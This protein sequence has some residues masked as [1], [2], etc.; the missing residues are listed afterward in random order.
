M[1]VT[2]RRRLGGAGEVVVDLAPLA[3]DAAAALLCERVPEL[4]PAVAQRVAAAVD[5]LPLALELVAARVAAVGPEGLLTTAEQLVQRG[6]E[7][8]IEAS[9]TAARPEERAGL[10]ALTAF[11]GPF[12]PDAGEAV[13]A[14]EGVLD[15]LIAQS[16]VSRQGARLA[17]LE[18]VR[19]YARTHGDPTPGLARHADWFATDVPVRIVEAEAVVARK[20]RLQRDH[21]ELLAVADRFPDDRGARAM[22]RVFPWAVHHLPADDLLARLKRVED[23]AADPVLAARLT[24]ERGAVVRSTGDS[25]GAQALFD[26]ATGRL[27]ALGAVHAAAMSCLL[28]AKC[29]SDA[30]DEDDATARLRRGIDLATRA[31]T[32]GLRAQAWT[33]LAR[34]E[35]RRADPRARDH[36]EL[37]LRLARDAGDLRTV[38]RALVERSR[39]HVN[40][41]NVAAAL[42]DVAQAVAICARYE[43]VE[44][45]ASALNYEAL[46]RIDAGQPERAADIARRSIRICRRIGN[47]HL[48]LYACSA[49]GFALVLADRAP[50]AATVLEEAQQRARKRGQQGLTATLRGDLGLALADLGRPAAIDHLTRASE[51]FAAIGNPHTAALYGR[52]AAAACALAGDPDRARS[53]WVADPPGTR[54]EAQLRGVIDPDPAVLAAERE[55]I[56][57]AGDADPDLR[58]ALRWHAR[59]VA[60]ISPAVTV[61][62]DGVLDL[63]DG[64]RVDLSRRA[65]PRR[66]LLHLARRRVEAPGA[67]TTLDQLVAVGWPGERIVSEAA[68]NRAYVAIATLRKAGLAALL[69]TGAEGYRLDPA[70]PLRLTQPPRP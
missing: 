51:A 60:A 3:I 24:V 49:L 67:S 43:D 46:A 69:Q 11:C 15:A 33:T 30:W 38:A 55:R 18:T 68:S 21:A 20:H 62:P 6:M 66:I 58:I 10:A 47:G 1:L 36:L 70:V 31:G 13:V 50:E 63:Q 56:E 9:W 42:D 59:R 12:D 57:A 61:G 44:G 29:S 28:G 64:T 37:A 32:D 45:E 52:Y 8:V 7:P 16:L 39:V 4:D 40:Q 5:R 23:G 35:A 2:S 22:L 54:E 41:R 48:E 14:Q 25:P 34:L 27:E 53:L 17:L 65:A 19:A 26:D